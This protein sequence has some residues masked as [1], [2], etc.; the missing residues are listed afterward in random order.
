M[1]WAALQ[2]IPAGERRSY[3]QIAAAIGQPSATRA[4]AQACAT[5]KVA[6]VVPCHRVVRSDGSLSGYKWGE[7]RKR[8][9]LAEETIDG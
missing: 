3:S 2:S 1:V 7:N 8:R 5:N 9:L 6:I 4:V